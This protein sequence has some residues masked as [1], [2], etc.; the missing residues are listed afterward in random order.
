MLNFFP[1]LTLLH[2]QNWLSQ[3]HFADLLKSPILFIETSSSAKIAL[4]IVR[5]KGMRAELNEQEP[6][7]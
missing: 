2:L 3:K 4:G 5:E 7:A 6:K 1:N